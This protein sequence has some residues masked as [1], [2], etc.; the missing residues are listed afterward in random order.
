MLSKN[1]PVFCRK[2]KKRITLKQGTG[3]Q[4]H[5]VPFIT[6]QPRKNKQMSVLRTSW[7]CPSHPAK[8]SKTTGAARF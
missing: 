5:E 6:A 8:L 1:W 2:E 7:A 3:L 4:E